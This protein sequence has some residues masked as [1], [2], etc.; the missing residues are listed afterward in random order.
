MEVTDAKTFR[1]STI[2]SKCWNTRISRVSA[3]RLKEFNSAYW[4][5]IYYYKK[6]TLWCT[7]DTNTQHATNHMA[8]CQEK[9]SWCSQGNFTESAFLSPVLKCELVTQS[10]TVSDITSRNVFCWTNSVP[11]WYFYKV[12]VRKKTMTKVFQKYLSTV[13]RKNK[14]TAEWRRFSVNKKKIQKHYVLNEDKLKNNGSCMET[15]LRKS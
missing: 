9:E 8:K 15:G 6:N 5:S 14:Y 3:S 13:S 11:W 1:L 10:C 12:S 7:E 2:F 4:N